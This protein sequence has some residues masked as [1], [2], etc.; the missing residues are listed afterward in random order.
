MADARD[1]DEVREEKTHAQSRAINRQKAAKPLGPI[2]VAL[3]NE[4]NDRGAIRCT[5]AATV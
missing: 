2:T 3:E 1:S 4:F 5:L